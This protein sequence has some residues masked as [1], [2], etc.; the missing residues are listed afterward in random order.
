[1]SF[2]DIFNDPEDLDRYYKRFIQ[3]RLV[4][5]CSKQQAQREWDELLDEIMEDY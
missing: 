1:M 4:E 3:K 5:G 2:S